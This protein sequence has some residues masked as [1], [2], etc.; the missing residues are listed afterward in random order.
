MKGALWFTVVGLLLVVTAIVGSVVRRLPLTTTLL[1]LGAGVAL[2]PLGVGLLQVEPVRD[3]RWVELLTEVAVLVSLFAA[4]LKLRT[5]LSDR[6]WHAPVRLATIVMVLTV[7]LLTLVGK[8]LLALPLGAAVLLGAILAPTDPVLAS[9][10]QVGHPSDRDRLRFSLTGEAALND[11]TA[12]PFVMLGLGLVGAHE[13]GDFGWRWL[14]V[15]VLWAGASGL[16]VGWGLGSAVSHLVLWLRREHKEAIG[17]DDLLALGLI[18]LAY[19]AALLLKGYGFLAVFAAGFA[20]RRTERLATETLKGADAPPDVQAA[21][22]T[23]DEED[24][25]TAPETAPA[26]MAEAA[27]G[28]TE[29]LERVAEVAVVLVVGGMLSARTLAPEAW[30]FVP[31]LFCVVRPIAVALGAPMRGAPALQ[32]GLTMWFGIRGIG[33]LYYLAYATEHGLPAPLAERLTGLVL[34]TIAASVVVHGISVTPLMRH[35]ETRGARG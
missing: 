30:W 3:A 5:A 6:R 15:D 2:G 23:S 9:D 33:S 14:A 21:A 13:L 11:G 22:Q 34:A 35:Y 29:Q 31:L 18:A 8:Y 19:G 4:G 10:V 26:Y 27:L 20:L 32:R 16:A 12:F 7:G 24:V 28:F 25:A 17:L 1:Y